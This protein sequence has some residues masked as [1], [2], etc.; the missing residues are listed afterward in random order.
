[1]I[2]RKEKKMKKFVHTILILVLL[3]TLI[4]C[5]A[6]EGGDSKGKS[7]GQPTLGRELIDLKKAKDGGA[8]S[9]QEYTKLK[10]MLMKS[11]E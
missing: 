8:I 1:L 7:I 9:M 6:I 2:G 3:L 5:L 4:S 11:Y 10:D